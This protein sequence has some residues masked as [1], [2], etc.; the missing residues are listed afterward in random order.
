MTNVMFRLDAAC[1][2]SRSGMRSS[3]LT[4][5]P[6]IVG[7]AR[8]FSPTAQTIAMS[9]SQLTSAKLTR[10][11]T[12]SWS[13]RGL[14]TVTDTLTSDV[15]TTS[16]GVLNRS[17]TS[18]NRRRKPCAI[19]I[20]VDVMS[21]TVTPRL[22]ASAVSWVPSARA[23]AVIMVPATSGR[24]EFRMRTGISLA[25]AGRIV[26]GCSTLAPKYASSDASLNDS[27]GT[28]RGDATTRGSA[29]SIPSTSVQI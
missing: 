8:R 20:R 25:T 24:R 27:R 2:T 22:H 12:M 21:T 10:L 23:S 19:S 18:N 5:R 11:L 17:K 13:R 14:S 7:S 3:E 15:V 6:K 28:R 4:A 16:T 9:G 29:V 26:L 1:E